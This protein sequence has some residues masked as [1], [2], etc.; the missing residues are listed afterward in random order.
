MLAPSRLRRLHQQ[1][2][3][4][5][6]LLWELNEPV[7]VAM[8]WLSEILALEEAKNTAPDGHTLSV[9]FD[10]FLASPGDTLG[11][12]ARF[13]GYAHDAGQIDALVSGP[14]M[15]RY[16][17]AP[18]HDYSADVRAKL[19][20]EARSA[21]QDGINTALTWLNDTASRYPMVAEAMENHSGT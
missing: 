9:D 1:L 18:D 15:T 16:S 10:T 21:N 2:G 20:A 8:S 11:E 3:S 6:W 17:K 5:D 13:F 14:L 4:E 7:R 19:L 12:I